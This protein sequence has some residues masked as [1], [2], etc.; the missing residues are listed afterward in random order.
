MNDPFD[1]N[2]ARLGAVLAL[3]DTQ[4][5]DY[6]KKYTCRLMKMVNYEPIEITECGKKYMAY[7]CTMIDAKTHDVINT[8]YTGYAHPNVV[9]ATENEC[10][11]AKVRF[12][13]IEDNIKSLMD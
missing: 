5:L 9:M 11:T 4:P 10:Y 13:N 1:F 8:V 12:E 7:L 6:T 2:K 3:K